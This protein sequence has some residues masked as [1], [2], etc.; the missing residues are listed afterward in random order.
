MKH[1]SASHAFEIDTSK[2]QNPTTTIAVFQSINTLGSGDILKVSA[3]SKNTVIA[4]I[5]FCK[6]S[7]NTL[8]QKIYINGVATLFIRKN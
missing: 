1:A 8:L 4:L 3:C 2:L 7:G 5:D 6:H